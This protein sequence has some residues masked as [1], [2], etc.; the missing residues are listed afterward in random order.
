MLLGQRL[1]DRGRPARNEYELTS[2]PLLGGS[3]GDL[4]AAHG[5]KGRCPVSVNP[6]H[7]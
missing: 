2:I 7:G 1:M 5:L 6:R 4:D 3:C